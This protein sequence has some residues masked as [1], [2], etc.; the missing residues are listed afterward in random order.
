MSRQVPPI[1][2]CYEQTDKFENGSETI[3]WI[4]DVV[5]GWCNRRGLWLD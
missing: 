2:E 1:D 4:I 3:R 5:E